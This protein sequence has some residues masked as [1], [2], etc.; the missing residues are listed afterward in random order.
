MLRRSKGVSTA[1]CS[2]SATYRPAIA[3]PSTE[4]DLREVLR[5]LLRSILRS[6]SIELGRLPFEIESSMRLQAAHLAD[7][8]SFTGHLAEHPAKVFRQ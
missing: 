2:G 1:E 8:L 4:R 3:Q 5:E 7:R 6:K